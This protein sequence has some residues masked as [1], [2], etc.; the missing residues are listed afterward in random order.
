MFALLIYILVI[1]FVN[2][3]FSALPLIDLGFGLFAPMSIMAG[4]VFVARDYA[5]RAVGDVVL[6]AMFAGCALSYLMADPNVAI[7]SAVSFAFSEFIDWII[8]SVTKRPFHKRVMISSL[9]ST[10]IDTGVF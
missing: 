3:G 2:I 7:A 8:F 4:A 10:P 5:Q 1:V 9:I 6:I